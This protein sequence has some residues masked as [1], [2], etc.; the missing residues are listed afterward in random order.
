MEWSIRCVASGR[1]YVYPDAETYERQEAWSNTM[2]NHQLRRWAE[3]HGV[4]FT[5]ANGHLVSDWL[6]Y[7]MWCHYQLEG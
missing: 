3:V 1:L 7:I 2:T 5:D 4:E 6:E